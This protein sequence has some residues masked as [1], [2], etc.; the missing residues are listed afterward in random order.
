MKNEEKKKKLPFYLE[1]NSQSYPRKI[2]VL[3]LSQGRLVK[4]TRFKN[5]RYLG[6]PINAVRIFN[7]K[8]ADEMV[9]LEIDGEKQSEMSAS[10]IKSIAAEAFFPLSFGGGIRDMSDVHQVFKMG[11][12]K[13]ILNSALHENPFLAGQAAAEYGSQA[14]VAAMEVL[15]TLWKGKRVCYASGKKRT[16]HAPKDWARRCEDYGCGELIV[17]SIDRDG[18]MQGYDLEI[19]QQISQAVSIPVIPLGGA[20]TVEH[21]REGLSAGASAVAAGSMFVF[22]GPRR[23]V[24]IT[25]PEDSLEPQHK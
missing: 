20:G 5:P 18:C 10:H 7:K 24:L 22:H 6:D 21:L 23:A 9:L 4:T 17:N 3:T 16:A 2:V 19:L 13:V 8:G 14:V 25:Y 15:S 11:F 1:E 12:E